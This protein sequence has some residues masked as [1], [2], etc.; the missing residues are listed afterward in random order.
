MI[1]SVSYRRLRQEIE[2]FTRV[3]VAFSGGVDSSLLLK[4]ALDCLGNSNVLAITVSSP[5]VSKQEEEEA[6]RVA[7]QLG[8]D[9]RTIRTDPLRIEEV[10]RNHS[11][12]C[13]FCKKHL[14]QLITALA[15]EAGCEAVLEG[16]NVSDT[17]DYRPGMAALNSFDLVKSPFIE[18]GITKAEIRDMAKS[19]ALVTWNKPSSA[20]LASRFPYGTRL[21]VDKLAQV[22]SAEHRLKIMGI[23]QVRVRYHGY[24]ARIEV[25]R[26]EL[27][28]VLNLT[29]L[30]QLS[31][32]VKSC[33][34]TYVALDLDGYRSGSMNETIR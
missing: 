22:A 24:L 31:E 1:L 27:P 12:R 17:E 29:T 4:V 34:F 20:C 28:D 14:F 13:F 21:S 2:K 6:Q 18:C 10:T 23:N 11:D 9:L 15:T 26:E 30:N 16:S 19:L 3:A 8:A 5:L 7:S 32:A 33:G 25:S